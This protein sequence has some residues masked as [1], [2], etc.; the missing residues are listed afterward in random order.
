MLTNA[1]QTHFLIVVFVFG[2]FVC[3][4]HLGFGHCVDINFK[5][6]DKL[7]DVVCSSFFLNNQFAIEIS[8]HV[9]LLIRPS[10][11]LVSIGRCAIA[12]CCYGRIKEQQVM[13]QYLK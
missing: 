9:L 6:S 5:F 3:N 8:V 12:S 4:V 7:R 13:E 10:V 1:R 11:E 2:P